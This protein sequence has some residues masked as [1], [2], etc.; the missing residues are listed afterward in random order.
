M[1]KSIFLT[2]G[3]CILC[4]SVM[5]ISCNNDSSTGGNS[6]NGDTHPSALVG[7]W[8]LITA[9]VT[10]IITTN[11]N[12]TVPD[13]TSEGTGALNVTGGENATLKYVAAMDSAGVIQGMA[14]N[15]PVIESIDLSDLKIREIIKNP[16]LLKSELKTGLTDPVYL[17]MFSTEDGGMF[18][19]MDNGDLLSAYMGTT[20]GF[21]F[22]MQT[23][24]LTTTNYTLYDF[25]SSEYPPPTILINGQL[26]G[27]LINIPA[28]TPTAILN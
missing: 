24:T 17:F 6:G 23:Y 27:V 8:N 9:T 10:D 12:Q 11:S 14:S 18:I 25:F 22:N 7:I 15:V 5:F 21:S 2:L 26:Q 19:V 28:N 4:L 13:L 3:L 20:N 1:K 16:D